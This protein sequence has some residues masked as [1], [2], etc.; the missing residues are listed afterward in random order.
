MKSLTAGVEVS[1]ESTAELRACG[2]DAGNWSWNAKADGADEAVPLFC[3][4]TRFRLLVTHAAAVFNVD[5]G[6]YTSSA[7]MLT[8]RHV[9]AAARWAG[10]MD[11]NRGDGICYALDNNLRHWV[12]AESQKPHVD[13]KDILV[14]DY[15]PGTATPTNYEAV[16]HFHGYRGVSQGRRAV[17]GIMYPMA[18]AEGPTQYD[19]LVDYKYYSRNYGWK[20]FDNPDYPGGRCNQQASLICDVIGTMGIEAEVLYLQR[21]GKGTDSGRAVR[22]FFNCNAGGQF[23]NFHGVVKAKMESGTWWC[24]DGSFSGPPRR[25]NGSQ[26][27]F[28][29]APGPFIHSWSSWSYDDGQARTDR[30]V[31][32]GSA[33]DY[34]KWNQDANT[35]LARVRAEMGRLQKKHAS[36]SPEDKASIEAKYK[37]LQKEEAEL[38]KIVRESAENWSKATG[39]VLADDQPGVYKDHRDTGAL[40]TGEWTGIPL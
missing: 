34:L 19:S 28:E 14:P 16:M 4:T 3:D 26:T 1:V 36:A 40:S 13:T 24:Y 30:A 25:K 2:A 20:V 23:W 9:D 37:E 32:G 33:K 31:H 6:G 10:M 5:Y 18:D 35:D 12:S 17:S 7:S 21:V 27:A 29:A 8:Q 39:N 22:Q 11:A 38:I 15:P